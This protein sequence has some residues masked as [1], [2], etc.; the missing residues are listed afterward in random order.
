VAI[1]VM[2][3]ATSDDALRTFRI[4][5]KTLRTLR[6]PNI[7]YF[8]D[9]CLVNGAPVIVLELLRGG[10][11]GDY[12]G[13]RKTPSEAPHASTA[14]WEAIASSELLKL[15]MDVA[16]G[17]T[18]LHANGVTHR[19]VKRANV[20]VQDVDH[21]AHA[22]LCDFGISALKV[23]HPRAE[24]SEAAASRSFASL[25]TPRYQAPELSRLLVTSSYRSVPAD[26]L[27]V[28][29]DAC[30]DVYSYGLLL[31][32][33]L[34]GRIVF[35][36]HTPYEAMMEAL[37]G[38]RPPILLRP[39]HAPLAAIVEACWHA[40]GERRPSMEKVVE[41]LSSHHMTRPPASLGPEPAAA[42]GR[43]GGAQEPGESREA[44]P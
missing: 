7:C 40:D 44:S 17:L 32:E 36:G 39:E 2:Q 9:T 10:T 18:Y 19:D 12:L 42:S 43:F 5:A 14:V 37:S 21:V 4:E 33:V 13:I 38:A 16:S 26:Q 8:F 28:V 15:A 1:K 25:G 27:H 34:H 41:A 30:V 11:L 20:M 6:H 35:G 22:K 31:H 3:S 29:T 23:G 24:L